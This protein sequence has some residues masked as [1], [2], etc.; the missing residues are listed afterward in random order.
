MTKIVTGTD[1]LPKGKRL[2]NP[3]DSSGWTEDKE[4]DSLSVRTLM[5]RT[6]KAREEDNQ[7][8]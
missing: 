6:E 2:K 3:W 8:R 4:G 1:T 5:D 7:S